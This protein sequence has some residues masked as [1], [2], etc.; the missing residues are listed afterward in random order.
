MISSCNALFFPSR[1]KRMAFSQQSQYVCPILY[2]IRGFPLFGG[3]FKS[4]DSFFNLFQA[5]YLDTWNL[6]KA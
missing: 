3:K 1:I 5:L 6:L 2:E 4:N